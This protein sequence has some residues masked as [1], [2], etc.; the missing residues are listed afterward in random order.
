MHFFK[1]LL[2][3]ASLLA[4]VAAEAPKITSIF[5]SLT[6]GETVT[7][8]WI[9]G[10]STKPVDL[11]LRSGNSGNLDINGPIGTGTGG[12]FTWVV[13]SDLKSLPSYAIEIKQDGQSNYGPQFAILGGTGTGTVKAT[14]DSATPT[15]TSANS[16]TVTTTSSDSTSTSTISGNV[17]STISLKTTGSTR[18][19]PTGSSTVAPNAN[20]AAGLAS[21]LAL[22][23]SA[24]MAMIYF[25]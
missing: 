6:P 25:N 14:T 21:P 15:P 3:G 23:L 24:V 18:A 8:T 4:L 2:A 11:I 1:A 17:T 22:V 9:G 13:P 20:T 19:P 7:I 12:S 5:T 16:T 10:D